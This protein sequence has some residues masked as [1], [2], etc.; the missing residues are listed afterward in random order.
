MIHAPAQQDEGA[1]S[2]LE[3][4]IASRVIIKYTKPKYSL[5]KLSK[6]SQ[7][8]STSSIKV[9]IDSHRQ[10]NAEEK[11]IQEEQAEEEAE[12]AEESSRARK[13]ISKLQKIIPFAG[14]ILPSKKP[15]AKKQLACAS[16]DT[17]AKKGT[18]T[19]QSKKGKQSKFS[20]FVGTLNSP[21]SQS[22]ANA[23][24]LLSSKNVAQ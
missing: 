2:Q 6:K 12:E 8:I 3:E 4:R 21:T 11:L 10:S 22:P 1:T 7:E 13:F 23:L 18:Q 17:R 9:S 20:V 16:E 15:A 14:M 19:F 24:G 5:P